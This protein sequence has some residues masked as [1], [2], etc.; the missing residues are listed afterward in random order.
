MPNKKKNGNMN[1]EKQYG[2]IMKDIG[3]Y[4]PR[5]EKQWKATGDI[6]EKFSLLEKTPT[7]TSSN[8]VAI[9]EQNPQNA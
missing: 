5:S 2:K 9:E 6:F 4:Y 3:L 7:T 1:F 8:T